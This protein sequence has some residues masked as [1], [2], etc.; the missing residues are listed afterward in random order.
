MNEQEFKEKFMSLSESLDLEEKRAFFL[1]I[2]KMIQGGDV[3]ELESMFALMPEKVQKAIADISMYKLQ[4]MMQDEKQE[5]LK[6]NGAVIKQDAMEI[7]KALIPAH[8][9]KNYIDLV[10]WALL[11]ATKLNNA[12]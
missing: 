2:S 6:K 10:D 12:C 7:L 8:P 5:K 1:F 9:D 3:K 4:A 11:M